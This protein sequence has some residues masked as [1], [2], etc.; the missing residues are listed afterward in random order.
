M[1]CPRS[2]RGWTATIYGD[3]KPFTAKCDPDGLIDVWDATSSP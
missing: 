1:L 2:E 3:G